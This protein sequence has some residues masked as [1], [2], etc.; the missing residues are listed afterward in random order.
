MQDRLINTRKGTYFCTFPLRVN[1]LK[2]WFDF[3]EV[4]G[5]SPAKI[6]D[7]VEDF[8]KAYEEYPD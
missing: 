4:F 7:V 1:D 3:A 6:Q 5:Y 8:R 2:G